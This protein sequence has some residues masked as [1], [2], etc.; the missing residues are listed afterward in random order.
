MGGHAYTQTSERFFDK[1]DA[2]FK[3][4]VRGGRVDYRTIKAD[5]AE[6]NELLQMADDL[7]IPHHNVAEF[8]A[9]WINAYNLSAIKGIVENYPVKS[10]L[11]IEGFF[12]KRKYAIGGKDISLD[13]IEN[14][15]LRGFFPDEPRFHFVLVCA[16][17]GCPPIIAE[18][19][20]PDQL[21][22]QLERQ[23]KK[24]INDP[25]FVRVGKNRVKV[26]QIFEWYG[27]DFTKN[28]PLS[29]FINAYRLEKIPDDAKIG[30]YA[31]DWSLNEW[32]P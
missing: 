10:P 14:R 6:L 31:Y 25:L 7:R 11:D 9:F 8:Q 12:D 26:S 18:A 3:T 27:E 23:T 32:K 1:A 30:Y 24:A 20:R 21:D 15:L 13:E 22:E 28:G 17:L 16:G 4:H 19:Y 5:G 29:D 2:F